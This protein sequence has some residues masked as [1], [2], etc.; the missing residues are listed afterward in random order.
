MITVAELDE[1]IERCLA[2]LA[3][4]PHSQVFAALAE[5]YRRRGEFAHAF[6]TCKSGLKHHPNYAPAH[7]VMAKLYLHQRMV[8][9]ALGSLA[10]AVEL[11]GPTRI[12]DQL[13]AEIQLASGDLEGAQH[14]VD[15]LKLTDPGNPGLPELMEQLRKM[16]ATPPAISEAAPRRIQ[17][18]AQTPSG[19]P[20]NWSTWAKTLGQ[21]RHVER[22]FAYDSVSRE[23]ASYQRP[24][25]TVPGPSGVPVLFHDL[26]VQMRRVGWGGIREIRVECPTIDIWACEENGFVLG[27][28]GAPAISFGATRRRAL[29]LAARVPHGAGGSTSPL[30]SESQQ[31]DSDQGEQNTSKG[32][33]H[34]A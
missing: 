4:N 26:D 22:V 19:E 15:R 32:N 27:V 25:S 24:R 2:I 7:V 5:A 13:E 12:T 28:I 9:E 31:L 11:E 33:D 3:D 21:L 10:R 17:T 18:G 16:R 8:V 14:A 34:A 23:V 29:E 1:R 6:A 20:I 30:T